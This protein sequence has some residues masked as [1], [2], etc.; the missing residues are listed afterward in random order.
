MAIRPV[1][2]ITTENKVEKIDIEFKWFSGQSIGQMQKSIKSQH[3]KITEI[4]MIN[5]SK[6][7]EISSKAENPLGISLSAFNLKTKTKV[8][9]KEYTVESAFQSSKVFENGGPYKDIINLSS[10][11]AKMDL[12]LKNSGRL[13]YFVFFGHKF[14]IEPE[15]AFYDWIYINVLLNN[16]ELCDQIMKYRAFT[17]IVFNPNKMINTQAHSIA[18]YVALRLSN[19]DM[20]QFN[21]PNIYLE[22]TKDFYN[23]LN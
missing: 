13:K 20:S 21:K 19:T 23:F 4:L 7:I 17:D 1:Y 11:E 3:K 6:I 10:K 12:R 5:Q 15:T 9:K 16:P 8:H 14:E 18:L 2:V 22:K